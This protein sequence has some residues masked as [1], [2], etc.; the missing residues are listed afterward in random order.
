MSA[1]AP[2]PWFGGKRRAAAL[3]WRALGD[4]PN[5][6]EPFFGSGASLLARP[7]KLPGRARTETV[8][9]LDCYLTNFWRAVR[10]DP[11]GV[12]SWADWPV[13]ELDLHAR[14]R[15]LVSREEVRRQ[16]RADPDWFDVQVA[17]WWVWGLSQWIGSGWCA[18]PAWEESGVTRAEKGCGIGTSTTAKRPS[19]PKGG[20]GVQQVSARADLR[21]NPEYAR[22]PNLCPPM[23][24]QGGRA[25]GT[26]TA[27]YEQRPMLGAPGGVVGR[28]ARDLAGSGEWD[29]RDCGGPGVTATRL[30]EQIPMLSGEGSSG[31]GTH[32]PPLRE[33]LHEKMPK[34][35]R[36]TA[37][38][39]QTEGLYQ[40]MEELQVRLRW[41]RVC[42]G[43]F[44]RVLGPSVTTG[45][46]VT[47]VLLDPP[48]LVA[49]GRDPSIYAEEDSTASER[50]RAWALEHG[51]DPKLRIVLC[52]Y[53]GEHEMPASWRVVKWKA[54]GGYAAAAG[55]GEN[56]ERE[57]LWLSPHCLHL[58]PAPE[59]LQLLA[60]DAG[61]G[62]GAMS[63]P[64]GRPPRA[65][66]WHRRP[67]G[68]GR[69]A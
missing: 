68:P 17:G 43:D 6:V 51:D 36:G 10:A 37:S 30:K 27:D 56:A 44:A 14:H 62:G 11:A 16:M 18:Q 20:R 58:E 35:N 13:S 40:W 50:A 21:S 66:R 53:E 1:R 61:A 2:F 52:G 19:L 46:G 15:W 45:I 7:P 41:V 25:R 63:V 22:R 28:R 39:L 49:A 65:A 67:C 3:I 24:V 38:R 9:D 26:S 12:A 57:R 34:A 54:A 23:G 33:A 60:A 42:C 8:N 55:N 48:Y 32:S 69:C 5:Y 4:P 59:Q 31:R 47:G 64:R 29:K